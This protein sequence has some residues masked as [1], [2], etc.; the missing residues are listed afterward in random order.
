[1]ASQYLAQQAIRLF[2]TVLL[3]TTTLLPAIASAHELPEY[4]PAGFQLVG[5]I[6]RIDT[7]RNLLVLDDVRLPYSPNFKVHT[8]NTEFGTIHDLRPGLKIGVKMLPARNGQFLISEVWVL[9]KDYRQHFRVT[10]SRPGGG[11][12]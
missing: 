12:S 9:P 2:W 11:K 4:Y 1:M 8:L 5:T 3:A 10:P 6:Q 7:S